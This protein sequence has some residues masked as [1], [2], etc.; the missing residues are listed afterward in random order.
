MIRRPPRSTRTDT[1]FPYTTLF[2]SMSE[3]QQIK[4]GGQHGRRN[5]LEGNLPE[6]QQ[7]LAQQGRKARAQILARRD[8]RGGAPAVTPR[9]SSLCMRRTNASSRSV[10]PT[11]ASRACVVSRDTPCPLLPKAL[12]RTKT[13]ASP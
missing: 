8:Q 9:N 10:P 11:R 1:L 3:N 12:R 5:G 7:L 13:W 2:R 4:Q 6:A